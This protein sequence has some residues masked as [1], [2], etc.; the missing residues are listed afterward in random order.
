MTTCA[1]TNAAQNEANAHDDPGS[2]CILL[3]SVAVSLGLAYFM[4]AVCPVD[5]PAACDLRHTLSSISFVETNLG[6]NSWESGGTSPLLAHT[7]A[8]LWRGFFA[9][10]LLSQVVGGGPNCAQWLD[11]REQPA[12]RTPFRS[13]VPVGN[14]I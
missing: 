3:I 6:K 8:V 2:H 13:G 9:S 7:L 4:G 12:A 1:G 11:G 10:V 14:S 5:E